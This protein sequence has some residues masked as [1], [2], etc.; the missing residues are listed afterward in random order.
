MIIEGLMVCLLAKFRK[1]RLRPLFQTW[2]FYPIL[3]MQLLLVI[4]QASIFFRQYLFLPFVPYLEPGVILS[5]LFSLFAFELYKP[6]MLGSASIAIGTVLNRLVIAQNGGHMPVYP[7]LSYLTGFI[8]PQVLTSLDHLHIAGGAGTKLLYLADYIDF[9]YS[10]LSPGD[11][12][13]HLFACIMF[14]ALIRAV[15][16]RFGSQQDTIVQEG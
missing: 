15:N 8:T 16:L 2:T 14:Y 6:A 13:I 1:Y 5:F 7:T 12:L 10:I 3:I 9:G 11:V 4:A